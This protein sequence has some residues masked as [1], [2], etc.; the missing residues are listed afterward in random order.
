MRLDR[1]DTGWTLLKR[2]Q[3]TFNKEEHVLCVPNLSNLSNLVQKK[4]RHTI[5]IGVI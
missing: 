2:L 5:T 4:I 3:R 1:L